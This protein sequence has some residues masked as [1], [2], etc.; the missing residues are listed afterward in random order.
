M[1]LKNIQVL[2]KQSSSSRGFLARLCILSFVLP[3]FWPVIGSFGFDTKYTY[4]NEYRTIQLGER[5]Q[6]QNPSTS[7][8]IELQTSHSVNESIR[9]VVQSKNESTEAPLEIE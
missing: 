3:V 5:F 6:L 4:A 2:S 7:F 8:T 1:H 9:F